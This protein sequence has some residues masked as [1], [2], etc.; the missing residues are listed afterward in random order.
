MNN[1]SRIYEEIQAE[2]RYQVSRWGAKA[3]DELNTPMDWV[4]YIARY[5]TNWMSGGFRPYPRDVLETFRKS[6]VKVAALAVAAVAWTD[7]ILDGENSRPDVL[8]K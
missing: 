5:S 2:R 6:M 4:G 8:K 1:E 7:R 3:D